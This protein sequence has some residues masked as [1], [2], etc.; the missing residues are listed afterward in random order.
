[1]EIVECRYILKEDGG[2]MRTVARNGLSKLV[3]FATGNEPHDLIEV[4]RSRVGS[5]AEKEA[6]NESEE[7]R[8]AAIHIDLRK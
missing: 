8:S 2:T 4:T 3:V 1:V 7:V 6:A 5:W